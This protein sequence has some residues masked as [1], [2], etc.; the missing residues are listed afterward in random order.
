MRKVK[1]TLIGLVLLLV[2]GFLH[3]VLPQHDIARITGTEVRRTDISSYNRLF[4][5]QADS[6][7]TEVQ[8][9]DIRY[10][11]AEIRKTW[12][13]GFFPRDSTKVMVYRNEDTGWI[14]P[15]YFKFDSSDLQ[16]E[17]AS[18]TSTPAD[19]QWVVITHYGWR[20]KYLT[21]FP[22]AISIKPVS[23]PD[24]TV[25]P[26][27]VSEFMASGSG[28]ASHPV[29]VHPMSSKI[30]ATAFMPDPVMPIRWAVPLALKGNRSKGD[31]GT[32]MGR[33]LRTIWTR[34]GKA[35]FLHKECRSV[36]RN[37]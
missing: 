21:I 15:P 4:Y 23:G 36:Q 28:S 1:Y 14:W 31:G 25:I 20:N 2:G 16:A 29:T 11:F 19:P 9:R 3:Y 5:A 13:L 7:S 30:S 24:V 10:I 27:F 35:P 17:A 6:G 12:L 18:A 33:L 32:S 26:W 8:N 22:N 37:S 34:G